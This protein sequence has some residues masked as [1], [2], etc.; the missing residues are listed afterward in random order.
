MNSSGYMD[1]IPFQYDDRIALNRYK[2]H[3]LVPIE[4]LDS[5]RSGKYVYI[6]RVNDTDPRKGTLG[7]LYIVFD[8]NKFDE[9]FAELGTVRKPGY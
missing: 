8:G 5:S 6:R 3:V 1:V 7:I 4:S 9:L 2:N